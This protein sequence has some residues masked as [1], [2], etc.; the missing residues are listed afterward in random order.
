MRH[1]HKGRSLSRSPAHRKALLSNLAQELFQHKR[2]R[3]TLGKARELRPF[4][5]KLVTAAKRGHVAAR[6]HVAR[7]IHRRAV[8]QSLFN[9]IA[10]TYAERNGGYTRIIKLTGRVGDNAP[11]AIVELVGFEGV[12]TARV[13]AEKAKAEK[14]AAK[15]GGTAPAATRPKKKEK[16]SQKA[17]AESKAKAK[18]GGRKAPGGGRGKAGGGKKSGEK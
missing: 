12:I 6:R 3:T 4:A 9:E 8:V 14:A 16:P 1:L 18:V 11:Q 7:F 5:E 15:K 13:E 10:P 17:Q 2:I